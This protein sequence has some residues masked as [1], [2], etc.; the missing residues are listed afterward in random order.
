[1]QKKTAENDKLRYLEILILT[2]QTK[3]LKLSTSLGIEQPD[4]RK[5]GRIKKRRKKKR[6]YTSKEKEEEEGKK[7]REKK[8]STERMCQ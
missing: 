1:M 3:R 5:Y 2:K 4:E 8:N 6:H 7:T